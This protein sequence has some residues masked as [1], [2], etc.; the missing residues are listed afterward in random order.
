MGLMTT[1]T[2]TRA[3]ESYDPAAEVVEI[4]RDLF[5]MDTA[6]LGDGPG[7]GQRK[8]AEDGAALLAEGGIGSE[9]C[10]GEPGR[11]NVVARWGSGDGHPLLLHGHLDVVPA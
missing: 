4:C 7:P 9:L 8:A 10:G 11:T 6:N 2:D 1:H 3:Q 5:R